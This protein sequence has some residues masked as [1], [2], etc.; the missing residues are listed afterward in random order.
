MTSIAIYKFRNPV[1]EDEEL[2]VIGDTRITATLADGSKSNEAI[3]SG[4]KVFAIPLRASKILP[5]REGGELVI[6]S[7]IG[8]AYA[9][10]TTLGLN[11][12]AQ[13]SQILPNLV[14]SDFSVGPAVTLLDIVNFAT[15]VLH[16]MTKEINQRCNSWKQVQVAEIA[17]FGR[18]PSDQVLRVFTIRPQMVLG[19]LVFQHE[20]TTPKNAISAYLDSEIGCVLLGD[21]KSEIKE[22]VRARIEDLIV[23]GTPFNKVETN[24]AM[25][26]KYVLEALIHHE[27]YSTIGGGLQIVIVRGN[28]VHPYT[29]GRPQSIN[30][31][32]SEYEMFSLYNFNVIEKIP[33]IGIAR[34]YYWPPISPDYNVDQEGMALLSEFQ[35]A[36][37]RQMNKPPIALFFKRR[38]GE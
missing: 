9:G 37:R 11:L 21:K 24:V 6:D 30:V 33:N 7:A 2:W 20:E 15:Y 19:E 3:S 27:V 28:G 13:L 29:W 10:N 36:L 26:P 34:M 32:S 18:C 22:L 4:A 8:M 31:P 16:S 5:S 12:Y 25:A 14:T 23:P 1:S 17:I 35:Q 38:L